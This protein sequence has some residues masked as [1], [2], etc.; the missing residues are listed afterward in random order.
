[1]KIATTMNVDLS[2]LIF[3]DKGII[4]FKNLDNNDFNVR[5]LYEIMGQ[6]NYFQY[7]KKHIYIDQ[8]K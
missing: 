4:D 8:V 5:S 7:E 6:G 2:N 1:M 3:L